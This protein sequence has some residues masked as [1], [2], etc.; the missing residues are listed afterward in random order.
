MSGALIGAVLAYAS[1]ALT[2][3][4]PPDDGVSESLTPASDPARGYSHFFGNVSVGRGLRL[5]NPYRLATPLGDGSRSLSAIA[6][7]LDLGAGFALGPPDG[8]EH[9]ARLALGVALDGIPQEVLTPSYCALL[10]VFSAGW[11][12][13]RLGIPVVL[14]PDLNVGLELGLGATWL[15][16]R[17]F[18]LELELVGDGYYG[19]ATYEHRATLIETVAIQLGV[20]FDYE[21]LP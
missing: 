16:T 17:S 3:T 1:S 11:L 8:I 2:A 7:Y 14:E 9:G 21:V 13:A 15:W 10:H 20:A 19:A 6:T 4:L 5:N 18:G 12:R